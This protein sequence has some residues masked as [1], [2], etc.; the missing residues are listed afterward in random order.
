ML[1]FTRPSYAPTGPNSL[2]HEIRGYKHY[3][4]IGSELAGHGIQIFDMKKVSC[5]KI[6]RLKFLM[7]H[8]KLLNLDP[9]KLPV[10][11]NNDVDLAGHF[12]D[13]PL[14]RTHK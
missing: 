9:A 12:S 7:T 2:W 6:K 8:F 11:F 10:M 13:L 1:I 3:M 5:G 14:G 4:L